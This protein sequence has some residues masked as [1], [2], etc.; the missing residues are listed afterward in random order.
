MLES[1]AF[2]NIR[3]R[4]CVEGFGL[5]SI[6][7]RECEEAFRFCNF[8]SRKCAECFAF[9]NIRL[10][11]STAVLIVSLK[12]KTNRGSNFRRLR[13]SLPD[14][15]ILKNGSVVGTNKRESIHPIT[16]P[17]KQQ[18]HNMRPFFQWILEREKKST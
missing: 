2:G 15:N 5:G 7:S 12:E 1:F 16:P 3:S 9:R 13:P 8:A 17:Q 18:K 4:K 14:E 6:R 11:K 10:R